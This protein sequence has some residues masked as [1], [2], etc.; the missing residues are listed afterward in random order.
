MR[1]RA[2]LISDSDVRKKKKEK[3]FLIKESYEELD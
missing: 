1:P 3:K 2:A